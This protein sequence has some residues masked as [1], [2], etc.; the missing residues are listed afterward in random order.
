MCGGLVIPLGFEPRTLPLKQ[1]GCSTSG[2]TV[3]YK[4]K[5]PRISLRLFL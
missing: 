1:A 5:K 2:A 4:K 3:F